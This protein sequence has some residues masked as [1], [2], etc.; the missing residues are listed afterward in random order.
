MATAAFTSATIPPSGREIV[1]VFTLSATTW[2]GTI[3]VDIAGGDAVELVF[4]DG[5]TRNIT[6]LIS[7]SISG[8]LRALTATFALTSPVQKSQEIDALLI[9]AGMITDTSGDT[10]PS[11][12]T[13]VVTN[14]ST[15][16]AAGLRNRGFG[17][18]GMRGRQ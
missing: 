14:N 13:S 6:S 5:D 15:L 1:L 11:V 7:T 9:A 4:P 3:T 18:L 8:N 12:A 2:A 17:R 10:T 16:S